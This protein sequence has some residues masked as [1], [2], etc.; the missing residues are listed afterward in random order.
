MSK[1]T[2]GTPIATLTVR[3][4]SSIGD[5]SFGLPQDSVQLMIESLELAKLYCEPKE[6][7][8]KISSLLWT[9]KQICGY[10]KAVEKSNR[11][12]EK[13]DEKRME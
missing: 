4:A 11:E 7:A 13:N 8:E 12:K 9:L 5:I 10:H 6:K 1:K 3:G 2:E